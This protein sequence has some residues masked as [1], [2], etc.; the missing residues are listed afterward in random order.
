M[1]NEHER[2]SRIGW[3]V[4]EKSREGFQAAGRCAYADNRE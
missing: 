3:Q 4:F 1:L 2:H